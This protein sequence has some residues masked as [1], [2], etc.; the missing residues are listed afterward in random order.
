M[1]NISQIRVVLLTLCLTAFSILPSW[2]LIG[3]YCESNITLLNGTPVQM[4]FVQTGTNDYVIVITSSSYKIT[5][6]NGYAHTSGNNTYHYGAAGHYSIS[7]DGYTATI[8]FTS[9]SAPKL[10]NDIYII[11]ETIGEQKTGIFNEQDISWSTPASCSIGGSSVARTY[12]GEEKMYFLRDAWDWWNNDSPKFFAYFWN[13]STDEYAW[14]GE[15][16]SI[17]TTADSKVVYGYTVPEGTWDHVIITRHPNTTTV[18]T[19]NNADNKSNDITLEA[20]TNLLTDWTVVGQTGHSITWSNITLASKTVYFDNRNV[21]DWTTAYVRIGHNSSNSAWGPMTK[22]AGTRNLYS[23]TTSQWDYHTDFSIAN[24]YGWTNNNNV[25]QPW[26]NQWPGTGNTGQMS[27]QTN[28]QKYGIDR[29]A[30]ICPTSTSMSER[31]CQYYKVNSSTSTNTFDSNNQRVALPQYN[32]TATGTNCTVTLVEYT[33][34]DFSTSRAITN[35]KVDPT[36][37]VGVTIAPNSGY[38]FSS[39]SL[40]ADSYEQHTAA[41]GTVY[42]IMADCEISVVCTASQYTITLDN[43]SATTAGTPSVSVTYDANTNLTSNISCP[44]KTGFIFGG[45]YTGTGGTGTQLIASNGAWLASVSGYTDGEKKWQHADNLE[46][47]AYWI[48]MPNKPSDPTY[49]L[50]QVLPIFSTYYAPRT[51]SPTF[52]EWGSGSA[53]TDIT[54][55]GVNVWQVIVGSLYQG[56]FGIE[57]GNLPFDV[58]GYAGLHMDIFTPSAQELKIYPINRNSAYNGNEQEKYVTRTT[59]AGSWTSINIPISEYLAQGAVMTR[60]YQL[61]VEGNRGDLMLL[62]NIYYYK[63]SACPAVPTPV[64][65]AKGIGTAQ[66][67]NA[68][69]YQD[70]N[71]NIAGRITNDSVDFYVATLGDQILYKVATTHDHTMWG[72]ANPFLYV[73]NGSNVRVTEFQG[74]RNGANTLATYEGTIPGSVGS[75]QFDWNLL[76]PL[77]GGSHQWNGR[78][79]SDKMTYKRGYVNIPNG[80]VTVPTMSGASLKSES[81]IDGDTTIVISGAADNSGQF[82]YYFESAD[83]GIAHI[84]LSNEFT[85]RTTTDG[86][87]LNMDCYVVDFNGNMSAK[88]T[89]SISM[90][91]NPNTNLALEKPSFA[92]GYATGFD[93]SKANDKENGAT[94]GTRWGFPEGPSSDDWW[95]YVDLLDYYQL[96]E[97]QIWFE[98]AYPTAYVLQTCETLP[99]PVTDDTKWRTVYTGTSAPNHQGGAAVNDDT[100]KNS[101]PVDIP[102]R[103][104]RFR[105]TACAL[106][107]WG[108]SIWDFRVYG[109]AVVAKDVTAPVITTYT[110]DDIVNGDELQLTLIADDGSKVF[111]I[112]DS[113]SNVYVKT[114]DA[115]NHVVMDNIAYSYCTEYTF[116][117]QAMDNAANLSAAVTCRGSVAPAAN[118]DLTRLDGVTATASHYPADGYSPAKA[119]DADLDTYWAS[120]GGVSYPSDEW[121]NIDLTRTWTISSV[122][123]AWNNIDANNL[124][125][126]GSNDGV[127]YYILKHVKATPSYSVQPNPIVYETY[128]LESHIRVRHIRLRAVGLPAEMAIRDVQIFGACNEDYA[129][130]VMTMAE[131]DEV[132]IT[133]STAKAYIDV[134][135]FDDVTLPQ[136]IRY[137]VVFVAGGLANRSNLTTTDG[138]L[139]L[140]GLTEGTTYTIRIYAVDESGNV[141]ENYKELTFTVHINLYYLTSDGTGAGGVWEGALGNETS[142]ATRRF[143]TTAVDGIYRFAI[144]VLDDNV[145]YR[146][147]Y[148]EDGTITYNS[149][150]WSGAD[151]QVI[152]AHSGETI[153]V[154]A[155]DKNH[156]VSNFDELKVYGAAV[157]AATEGAAL[158]MTYNGDHTFSWEGDVAS[159]TNAFRIIVN[160]NHSGLT[161][162]SRIRIMDTDANWNNASSWARA[163]LTFDMTTWTWTWEEATDPTQCSA[164]GGPGSGMV[165]PGDAAATKFTDGYTF[166]VKTGAPGHLLVSASIKDDVSTNGAVYLNFHSQSGSRAI[167]AEECIISAGEPTMS[168]VNKDVTIPA[169]VASDPV[170]ALSVKFEII[171]TGIAGEVRFTEIMYYN[172]EDGGCVDPT[173]DFF[174]IYHADDATGSQRTSFD[175]GNIVLPIRYFRHF[176]NNWTTITV[177]FEVEKVVVYDETDDEE[178]PLFPRFHNN[179]KDV[180]GYYYLKTFDNWSTTSVAL[181]DFQASWKQL[182]VATDYD[183]LKAGGDIDDAQEVWLSKNVKPA[184]NTPYSIKFPYADYYATNWVI[185][186]G[187]AFQTIASDFNGGTSI[188]LTNDNYD[189]DQVKLQCNNTMHPTPALTNIYMI[190]EGRDLFTRRESQSVPAFEAY[191]I[192]TS[193]VQARFS[194][195]RWSGETT[196]INS[197]RPSTADEAGEIYTVSG[198]RLATFANQEQMER[199]LNTFASGV[200]VVRVGTRI[201]KVIVH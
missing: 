16:T 73:L 198:M 67:Q 71:G 40:T 69:M 42:A 55:D 139:E 151:N 137:N 14:S 146:P 150:F 169:A 61:K 60:N 95:W 46:L 79:L 11:F 200:Y 179:T 2:A 134:A 161:A 129:R 105:A 6:V 18:P 91:F 108:T 130:P 118:L 158:T 153:E 164:D 13:S 165:I 111:R 168:V 127:N 106:S 15:A 74:T 68:L 162:N 38:Q 56:Y 178:Y 173:T 52:G 190:E 75:T 84:S 9:T 39:I 72:D 28:Y 176:D 143:S 152:G 25:Y 180:E 170:L 66:A 58:S 94:F 119:I 154:Y 183:G 63:T 92:G 122:N 140:T 113:N 155:K 24:N 70:N 133:S 166:S 41:T 116:T 30:Y 192:G 81:V 44:T 191:V 48:A 33:A 29:D 35:N 62:T 5:A 36:R 104:V 97:I 8:P 167:Y 37:Y 20:T 50:C 49:D 110:V 96:S 83:E 54:I 160:N 141:S 99:D 115:S 186:Y 148:A 7:D 45:Y 85:I 197:E 103:Y 172:L 126:E 114:A 47:K 196:A 98:D 175:G 201:N 65:Q 57:W 77:V 138:V 4:S 51:L 147:Y 78:A 82:F 195:L 17:T 120:G 86:H 124:Y 128:S 174:D 19:F 181:K 26:E 194:V 12:D 189:Y 182:T 131:L 123:V 93:A 157:G 1:K 187:S 136:N 193:Q 121:L 145:Q 102:A 76:V 109:S 64:E 163:K 159:G 149:N 132:H 59:S 185:F 112:T 117:V 125:I 23:Q 142:A 199:Y 34:D 22:V 43:Q 3:P 21:T 101:Y 184:K 31:S 90:P 177:P 27:A 88:Q 107:Q 10:Y 87:V 53:K 156:F 89:V 188:T 32:V 171:G 135:A 144:T 100:Y 80:D